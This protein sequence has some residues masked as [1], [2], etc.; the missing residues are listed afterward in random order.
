[1]TDK[2]LNICPVC[3]GEVVEVRT[4]PALVWLGVKENGTTDPNNIRFVEIFKDQGSWYQCKAD[5]DHVVTDEDGE[6]IG[7]M[8]SSP[9]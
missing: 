3:G 9:E 2:V 4:G 7:S 1:M 6:L 5:E 8:A